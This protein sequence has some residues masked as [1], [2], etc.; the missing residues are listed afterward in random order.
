VTATRLFLAISAV[1]WLPYG[2]VCLVRPETVA[3]LTGMTLDS[4]VAISEIRAMYGGLQAAIG[5]LALIGI[6]SPRLAGGSLLGLALL[7]A[8]LFTG[9]TYGIV[10]GSDL[11][12]YSLGAAL[13]E[14]A[15]ALVAARFWWYAHLPADTSRHATG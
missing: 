2:I 9:R 13:F 11:S 4:P 14:S 8:G 10:S 12:A 6:F 1:V 3:S 7:C 15:S 5:I